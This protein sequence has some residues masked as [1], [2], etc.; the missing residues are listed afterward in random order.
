MAEIE[1][2]QKAALAL[3]EFITAGLNDETIVY[4]LKASAEKEAPYV[5]CGAEESTGEDIGTGNSAIELIVKVKHRAAVD[6]D[7]V[8]PKTASDTLT[9]RIFELLHYDNLADQLSDAL[10]D[11]TVMGF[12]EDAKESIEQEGDFWVETWRRRA[13]CAGADL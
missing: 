5:G 3:I 2:L 9:S 11:F 8:D 4:N 13:Y 7:A 6:T 10:S 1:V 12:F